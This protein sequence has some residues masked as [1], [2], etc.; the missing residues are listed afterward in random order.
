MERIGVACTG[1]PIMD[2]AHQDLTELALQFTRQV[3]SGAQTQAQETAQALAI[4]CFDHHEFERNLML[5]VGDPNARQHEYEHQVMTELILR[6]GALV[7]GARSLEVLL[8]HET[9]IL[10]IPW[11]ITHHIQRFDRPLA[12][13][14]KERPVSE[15]CH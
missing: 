7:G 8:A 14:A 15:L 1:I 3:S 4:A 11:V 2:A 6:C 10:A 9:M 5:S 12:R 13:Q